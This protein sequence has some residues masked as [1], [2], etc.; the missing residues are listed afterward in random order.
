MVMRRRSLAILAVLAAG[1]ATLPARTGAAA[2]VAGTTPSPAPTQGA[3]MTSTARGTFDVQLQAL[4][5]YNRDP[6]A[7][8]ARMAIDKRFHGDLE[9]TGKGEMISA[10]NPAQGS[11][12]YVAIERVTATLH[13]R[14]GSF[15]LQHDATITH[16][17]PYLHIVVV[18]GSGTGALAGIEG[19]MNIK[20]DAGNHSYAFDYRLPAAR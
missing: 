10:G 20:I 7:K 19:S 8:I 17:T 6:D 12:G 1:A 4:E 15:V 18:P 2:S 5:P 9:G 3:D 14:S 16:G 13:G 11:A